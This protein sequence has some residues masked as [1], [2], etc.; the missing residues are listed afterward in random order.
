MPRMSAR[1]LGGIALFAVLLGLGTYFFT[2]PSA[3]LA[4][5]QKAIATQDYAALNR[6]VDFPALRSAV[7]ASLTRELESRTGSAESAGARMGTMLGNLVIGPVVDLVVSPVGLA[8]ILKGY[9]PSE[10]VDETRAPHAASTDDG[11]ISYTGHWNSLSE[12]EVLIRRGGSP[13]S[14][15]LL[16]RDG[17]FGWKLTSIDLTPW[18]QDTH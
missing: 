1:L 7:K 16:H 17:L 15:L 14:T 11:G 6:L 9:Q 5:L 2:R 10:V 3:T 4:S 8:L 13:V 12:Y 18:L